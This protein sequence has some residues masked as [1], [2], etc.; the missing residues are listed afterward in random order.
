MELK[1]QIDA[2][3]QEEFSKELGIGDRTYRNILREKE[4]MRLK[5]MKSIA[6][7]MGI[8]VSIFLKNMSSKIT[9]FP[10]H[11][12]V[13]DTPNISAELQT[14]STW[15]KEF[16]RYSGE[17]QQEFAERVDV[18]IDTV[19]CLKRCSPSCNPTLNTLQKC[20]AHMNITVSEFLDITLSKADM[21][22]ILIE[23]LD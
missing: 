13:M 12:A 21:Q 16:L 7:G 17:T 8:P 11:I 14:I 10:A 4:N 2:K 23:R 6:D 3:T 9:V 19:G 1:R 22:K 20:V 5:T 18:S 15:L